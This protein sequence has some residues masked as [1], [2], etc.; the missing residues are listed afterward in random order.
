M[1][2]SFIFRR[3]EEV[4]ATYCDWAHAP[5]DSQEADKAAVEYQSIPAFV[6]AARSLRMCDEEL[7]LVV[8]VSLS[9][10]QC[11][12]CYD[13]SVCLQIRISSHQL[14]D[15]Y[16]AKK[17]T[18]INEISTMV[19]KASSWYGLMGV[20][21][22]NM[23][24]HDLFARFNNDTFVTGMTGSKYLQCAILLHM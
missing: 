12:K 10:L 18:D 7:P 17:Y 1:Q 2:I 22:L 13:I 8:M 5:N 14:E 16:G 9:L 20:S 11:G 6:H 23:I 4:F 19:Y 21:H 3:S 24:K 15:F